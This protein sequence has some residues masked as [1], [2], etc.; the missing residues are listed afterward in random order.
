MMREVWGSCCR[1]LVGELKALRADLHESSLLVSIAMEERILEQHLFEMSP[2]RSFEAS[3][4]AK[5]PLSKS[6]LLSS[7]FDASYT[8]SASDD[9]TNHS[10]DSKWQKSSQGPGATHGGPEARCVT[11]FVVLAQYVNMCIV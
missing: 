8:P 4:R 2:F 5:S 9:N 7:K 1:V 11:A 6:K 10:H 3:L